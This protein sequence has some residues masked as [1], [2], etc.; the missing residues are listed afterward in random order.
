M[1][2]PL[3]LDQDV[4]MIVK[5]QPDGDGGQLS[6]CTSCIVWMTTLGMDRLEFLTISNVPANRGE[7]C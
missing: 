3:A 5:P 1:R 4:A 7:V 6:V 2:F